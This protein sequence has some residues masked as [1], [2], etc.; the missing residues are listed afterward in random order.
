MRWLWLLVASGVWPVVS[1]GQTFE[2]IQPSGVRTTVLQLSFDAMWIDD[3]TA[4][5]LLY[6]RDPRFDSLDGLYAGYFHP[7]LNRVLRFPRT[8][9]GRMWMAD[10]DDLSPRFVPLI[11]EV[12]PL[13]PARGAPPLAFHRGAVLGGL[14]ADFGTPPWGSPLLSPRWPQTRIIDSRTVPGPPLAPVTV[15]L[16]NGGPKDLVVTIVN[17]EKPAET[18]RHRIKAGDVVQARFQRRS[19]AERIHTY[20]VITGDG[21]VVTEQVSIPLAPDVLYEIIVHQ[22]QLQS[23][24]IDRTGKSPNPIEDIHFQGKG[25]GRFPLPP[26]AALGAGEIDV[27]RAAVQRAN[28]AT[29]PPITNR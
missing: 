26:G 23:I 24:A 19:G 27:F 3:R 7:A 5:R 17:L 10:L 15:G 25:L 13:G 22:W 18:R 9:Q 2:V 6:V 4:G 12:R 1:W 20:R 8:G 11:G 29:V 28:P 21:D 14:G 16:R